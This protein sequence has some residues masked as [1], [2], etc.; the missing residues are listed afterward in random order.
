MKKILVGSLAILLIALMGFFALKGNGKGPEF[1]TEKVTR[2]D[3]V[4]TVTAMD[5]MQS[6]LR[7]PAATNSLELM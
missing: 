4:A 6:S 1:R 2:G 5:G 3:I 7:E